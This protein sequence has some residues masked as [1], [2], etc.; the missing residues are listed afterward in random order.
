LG[1]GQ[2]QGTAA[3]EDRQRSDRRRAG[4]VVR[5]RGRGGRV[6]YFYDTEFLE[7][8]KTIDLISIG[9]VAEDGR[10]YYAVSLD[11]DWQRVS[12]HSWL[13]V[14]VLPSLPR[15]SEGPDWKTRR[16]LAMEVSEFITGD[17]KDN[18]LC[19]HYSA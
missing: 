1:A 16:Q 9:I 13:A 5:H 18:E 3:G 6:K 14:N 17:R 7:D 2:Q 11:A 10:E 12:E 8:G 4:E 15:M 19:A